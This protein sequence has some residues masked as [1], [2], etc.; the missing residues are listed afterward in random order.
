MKAGVAASYRRTPHIQAVSRWVRRR[1]DIGPNTRRWPL[2]PNGHRFLSLGGSFAAVVHW[3][4]TSRAGQIMRVCCI[5]R[6]L[7]V[8]ED[9]A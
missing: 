1:I 6:G 9:Q 5:G 4:A 2:G 8:G 3:R 7:Y